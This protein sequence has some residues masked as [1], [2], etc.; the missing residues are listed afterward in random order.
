MGDLR[1][2]ALF[3]QN[4]FFFIFCQFFA[5]AEF[6]EKTKTMYGARVLK[7]FCVWQDGVLN[8]GIPNGV[9]NYGIPCILG[10][11]GPQRN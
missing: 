10:E 2:A 9:L 1:L 3:F 5:S 8:F 11:R 6:K 4:H 7:A